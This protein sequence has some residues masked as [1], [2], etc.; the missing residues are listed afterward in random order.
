MM[1]LIENLKKS[2]E[3]NPGDIII[4]TNIAGRGI[5]LSIDKLLEANGGL[6]VILSY[7]PGNLLIQPQVLGRTARVRKRSTDVYIVHDSRKLM[8]MLDMAIDFLLNE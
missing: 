4:A 2:K 3:L 1:G 6:H 7:M 8:F 5:D